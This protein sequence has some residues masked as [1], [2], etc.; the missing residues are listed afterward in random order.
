MAMKIKLFNRNSTISH[1]DFASMNSA[2]GKTFA[3][4]ELTYSPVTSTASTPET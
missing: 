2:S 3:H 1:T 4:R